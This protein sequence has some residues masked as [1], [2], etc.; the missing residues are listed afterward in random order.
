MIMPGSMQDPDMQKLTGREINTEDPKK[1]N[2][3]RR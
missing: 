2:V 1:E 3:Y